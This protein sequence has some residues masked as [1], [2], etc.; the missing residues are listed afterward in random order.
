M[1]IVFVSNYYNHHQSPFSC[2]MD[3]LLDHKYY[4]VETIPMDNERIHLGWGREV[5]PPFVLRAYADKASKAKS[6][7]LI[8]SADVVIY[9]NCNFSY[10]RPRLKAHKLTFA[11][12]ERLFKDDIWWHT[13]VRSIKYRIKI[14][15]FQ[16]DYHRLLCAS[17]YSAQD[18]SHIGL[19]REKCYKW[20]YFPEVKQ[21]DNI[22]HLIS[23][24]KTNSLLWCARLIDWK[25]PEVAI[26]I[27]DRLRNDGYDFELKMIGDG[28]RLEAIKNMIDELNLK[29]HVQLL[30]VMLPEEVRV[31]M[32]RSEIFL[33]TSDRNEG[34]GAVL[35]ESMNSACAVVA[36]SAIG[37][38]SFLIDDGRNGDI[39]K[40]G[41]TDELYRKVKI[42]LDEPSIRATKGK[43]AYRTI[44][45]QWN[46]CI[47]AERFV[48]LSRELL[49]ENAKA[50][51]FKT[52]I[53][54][55]AT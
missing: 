38:A 7:N 23:Q 17:S 26:A 33:F 55:K 8:M 9:G 52:G 22:E 39:Y 28:S 46:A 44:S 29:N 2:A 41:Y 6:F 13:L 3:R 37:S 20:G 40:D 31:Y 27:A 10:I 11:Y 16:A 53:C 54:S 30:G 47:A 15:A 21:Y 43:A 45:E 18:Y 14:G 25:H 42:L 48:H 51:I 32:E 19:F 4:F 36:S 12:S 1:T 50:D 35:N 34:W 49:R 24:K 5:K